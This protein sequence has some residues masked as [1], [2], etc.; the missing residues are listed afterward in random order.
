MSWDEIVV[1]DWSAGN[2]TGPRPEADA[3][4]IGAAG[5]E[6]VYCRNRALAESWL[7][8]R[9]EAALTTDRRLMLCFDF[10][11]GYPAGFARA[12]TGRDDPLA[13]W[14]WLEERIEDA[15][16]QNN[17]FDVAASLNRIFPGIGP[18]WGNGLKREIPDLPRRGSD[19]TCRWKQPRREAERLAPGAFEVWQLAYTGAVGSQVLMGLPVLERLR[20]RFP[21]RIAVWPFE[22]L[23]RPVALVEV[24]PSL[25][26]KAI[27]RANPDET[28]RDRAQVSCL[29]RALA[30]QPDG[31]LE[32]MLDVPR[33]EEGWILGLGHEGALAEALA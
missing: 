8:E 7:T 27:A 14:S 12:I 28:I 23:D 20:T 4:W 29:A 15:P 2:D 22:P 16:K 1:V 30:A 19:R 17:R 10:A 18:F 6:P 32:Q 11:F 24:W 25:I 3:I 5:E 33:D 31:R 26:A 13:L 9:I 21:G